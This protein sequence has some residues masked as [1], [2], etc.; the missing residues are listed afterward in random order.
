M[1]KL[2]HRSV[3]N[4]NAYWWKVPRTCLLLA[5]LNMYEPVLKN[6]LGSFIYIYIYIYTEWHKKTGNFE[7]PN[8]IWRNPRKKFIDRNWTIKTCLLRDSNPNYHCLKIHPVD[9]V[10]LHVRILSLPLRISKVPLLL[11]HHV[12]VASSAECDRVAF[13]R[14]CNT[15]RVTQ[16]NGNFWNA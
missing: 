16:K 13:C 14:I 10:L 3:S 6:F 1:C 11:C 5:A 15:H 9:G 8:K 4:K 7:K 2:T 12:C